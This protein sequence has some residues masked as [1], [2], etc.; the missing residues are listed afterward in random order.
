MSR[1]EK[2]H[3]FSLTELLIVCS[4]I[5]VL[6]A[7]LLPALNKARERA[8]KISCLNNLKQLGQLAHHYAGDFKDHIITKDNGSSTRSW[9]V[10]Y[11]DAGYLKTVY[12]PF[13]YCPA[14]RRPENTEP[15]VAFRVYGSLYLRD[16]D[17]PYYRNEYGDFKLPQSEGVIYQLSRLRA[18]ARMPLFIDSIDI[19]AA[20]F[21]GGWMACFRPTSAAE[22]FISLNHADRANSVNFDGSG[23]DHS[24][25]DFRMLKATAI[26]V[27]RQRLNL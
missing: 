18:P 26:A 24:I 22:C 12:E 9:T 20:N 17:M 16:S 11:R 3:L 1:K 27:D 14:R 19:G 7:L 10:Y 4:I 25:Y 5:A 21:T 15:N 13:L 8:Q 23:R 6:A 2:I